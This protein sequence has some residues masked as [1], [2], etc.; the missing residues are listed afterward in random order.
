MRED[1]AG[2]G[3]VP[4]TWREA[5]TEYWPLELVFEWEETDGGVAIAG[6]R[7]EDLAAVTIPAEIDGYKV[8]AINENAF[9]DATNLCRV[10]FE[11]DRPAVA[12]ESELLF[13]TLYNVSCVI[14]FKISFIS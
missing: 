6:V 12:G 14:I 4:G 5:A 13:L 1:K 11:G 2:W 7:C 10:T 8:V 9:A 3:V